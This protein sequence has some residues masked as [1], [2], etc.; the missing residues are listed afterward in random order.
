MTIFGVYDLQDGRIVR[1]REYETRKE[2]LH[3]A[4]VPD[5]GRD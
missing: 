2:A 3:A 1:Y 5:S 4:G